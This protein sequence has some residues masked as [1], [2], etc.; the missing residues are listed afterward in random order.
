AQ[1]KFDEVQKRLDEKQV[2]W[3]F[4]L[5]GKNY[6]SFLLTKDAYKFD[7]VISAIEIQRQ[8]PAILKKMGNSG[9]RMAP[10]S[11]KT[12]EENGWKKPAAELM[13]VLEP[14]DAKWDSFDELIVVPDGLLWYLPFEILQ[15]GDKVTENLCDK[16]SI[17]YAPTVST[18]VPDQRKVKPAGNSLVVAGRL[19]KNQDKEFTADELEKLKKSVPE[20]TVLNKRLPFDSAS[21]SSQIDRLLIWDE[22]E[23]SEKMAGLE[24]S[25]LQVDKDKPRS[26]IGS[27]MMLPFS[28]P[29]QYIIPGYH[30]DAGSG[31]IR[32]SGHEIFLTVCGM[33]ASGARTVLI[34]RWAVG[35]E[36]DYN[37]TRNFVMELEN[38]S[39]VEAWEKARSLTLLNDINPEREPRIRTLTGDVALKT[40]HPFF[41]SGYLLVDTGVEPVREA[42][43]E[44]GKPE[45]EKK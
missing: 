20:I 15:V 14:R 40:D 22:I 16:I 7:Q 9:S 24:W 10:V 25:P 37:L 43:A 29:E 17:R 8:L 31:R 39:A 45:D 19:T 30:T 38:T 11:Q 13:A 33:M 23:L 4:F 12:L 44:V 5:N 2:A 41:W 32:R 21:Y 18:I 26:S 34:S 36:N 27:W 42:P 3:I 35:G 6:Y 28:G 1:L